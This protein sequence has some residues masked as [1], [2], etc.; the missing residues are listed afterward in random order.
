MKHCWMFM[1]ALLWQ[2]GCWADDTGYNL[3][4]TGTI[5]AQACDVEVSSLSQSIDLGQFA[6]ADFSSTGTT[7]KFK[8]FNINL[9]NCS[10]GISGTKIWFTG[11]ADSDN[12]ALLALSETGMGSTNLLATGVGVEISDGDDAIA[13]NNTSSIDYSL[14]AGRNT[15][16]FYIRYKSTR[17]IVTSGNATAVMYFDLQYE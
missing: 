8:P 1:L 5:M 17:P 13:I 10:R 6:V 2:P 14:K 4:F 11:T 3:E 7:T 15:L 12:P 16:S 9:K